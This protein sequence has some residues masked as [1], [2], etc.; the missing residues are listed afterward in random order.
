[1]T[2][3]SRV[4]P[5][6]SPNA[7]LWFAI[8]VLGLLAA[9]CTHAQPRQGVYGGV[10]AAPWLVV[11]EEH[12]DTAEISL[13]S[14]ANAA[15]RHKLA[16][17]QHRDG[18]GLRASVSPDGKDVVY[19]VLPCDALDPDSQGELWSLPLAGRGSRRLATAVDLR[20]ALVWS[21]DSAW[22]TYDRIKQD[23]IQQRRVNATG[24]GDQVLATS[25]AE[26]RWYA[27]GYGSEGRLLLAHLTAAGTDVVQQQPNG[28]SRIIMHVGSGASRSFTVSPDGRPALLML[29][30]QGGRRLYRAVVGDADGSFS[31]LT[32]GGAEDTGIAWNPSNGRPSVGVV[33]EAS[34]RA[35]AAAS[36]A[37][38]DVPQEGFDVP[39]SWSPDGSALVVRHFTGASTDQPGS[40]TVV[41]I[42]AAG[43]RMELPGPVPLSIAGWTLEQPRNK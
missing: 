28:Q 21:P 20:S 36:N 5:G 9:G 16:T 19:V 15:Q 25:T 33:P 27:M 31:R 2:A 4:G 41:M 3:Q 18:W 40:E 26:D 17:V 1:M 32:D 29:M 30:Q 23:Q 38:I 42:A 7:V 43:A 35:V 14:A 37:D 13:V 24:A 22:I 39:V 34:D 11:V 10:S 6:R 12:S 8:S